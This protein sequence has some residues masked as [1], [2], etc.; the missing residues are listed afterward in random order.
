MGYL[1]TTSLAVQRDLPGSLVVTASYLGVK[2]TRGS[3]YTLWSLAA[4]TGGKTQ[5]DY[6]DLARGLVQAQQAIS[7]YYILGY[8]TTNAK[9]DG[10]F[11]GIRISLNGN[12]SAGLDY[13]WGYY[14]GKSLVSSTPPK[15]RDNSKTRSY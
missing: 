7:S 13:R 5:L 11:R 3:Q 2:G 12:L 1:R 15:R 14:A 6:N 8:Y 9:L 10:K 4:D